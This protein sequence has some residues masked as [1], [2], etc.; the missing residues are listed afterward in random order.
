MIMM[1][2]YRCAV[3]HIII[4]AIFY[5]YYVWNKW[6][7]LLTENTKMQLEWAIYLTL[8]CWYYLLTTCFYYCLFSSAPEC[9]PERTL[10]FAG[11]NLLNAVKLCPCS[12]MDNILRWYST[13]CKFGKWKKTM[14][15]Q[16]VTLDVKS[17]TESNGQMSSLT[18]WVSHWQ[19]WWDWQRV[20]HYIDVP[21]IQLHALVKWVHQSVEHCRNIKINII[22]VGNES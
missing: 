1:A 12:T 21:L 11:V 20:V 4:I 18:G 7:A 19:S 3:V 5:Y 6:P 13:S 16:C 8:F 10:W 17:F 22:I 2:G 14:G 9:L 15:D